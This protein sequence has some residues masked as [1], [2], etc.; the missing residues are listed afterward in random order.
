MKKRYL[1]IL[2]SLLIAISLG[3]FSVVSIVRGQL[4]LRLSTE[5]IGDAQI[6]NMLATTAPQGARQL[7]AVCVTP[8]EAR[9]G[10]LGFSAHSAVDIGSITKTFTAELLRKS[11]RLN[12]DS[13]IGDALLPHANTIAAASGKTLEETQTAITSSAL[14][15]TTLGDLARHTSGLPRIGGIP[16]YRIIASSVFNTNP[17]SGIS[18]EDVIFASL[19]VSLK[20]AGSEQYSNLGIALLGQILALDEHTTYADLLQT[21]ILDPLGM[22][23]TSLVSLNSS[24]A[25]ADG[26]DAIGRISATWEMDGYQPAGALRSTATDMERWIRYLNEHGTPDYTWITEPDGTTWHNGAT[27]G[28][29]SILLIDATRQYGVFVAGNTTASV[30]ITGIELLQECAK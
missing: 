6:A 11:D 23:K 16:T 15:N 13:K 10:G 25:P 26:Y 9:T 28:F 27:G 1:A 7:S 12:E 21:K 20:G 24:Y 3:L 14:A 5:H 19:H 2:F 30:D 4:N 8:T 29:T 18:R 22:K 17:Y